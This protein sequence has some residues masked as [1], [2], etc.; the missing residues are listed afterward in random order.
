M[1]GWLTVFFAG[2][3]GYTYV[4]YP[5]LVGV[6]A[7]RRPAEGPYPDGTPATTLII[8]AFNERDVIERKLR[9]AFSLDYPDDLLQIVVVT[10]G[11][12]DGTDSVAR[13]VTGRH[14]EVL[15][16]PTRAG[17]A[18][19][20]ARGVAAATGE[21]VVFSD[22]NN[23]YPPDAIREVVRPF[24][25]PL[26]GAVTG[27]KG[28]EG[29]AADLETE[30]AYW[31]Y[32]SFIKAKES[33]LGCCTG[34]IG[35]L[36]AVRRELVPEFPPGLVND[37]FF[38]AMQVARS[39]HKVAYAP[40][41]LSLEPTATSLRSDAVR[42][43]RMTAGRWQSV[44]WW[45]QVLPLRR[46]LVVWQVASHKYLRLLLPLTMGGALLANILDV[47]T[48]RKRRSWPVVALVAQSVFYGLA[49]T[50]DRLRRPAVVRRATTV[51]RYLVR[52]NLAS[53]EG[54][55]SYVRGRG[56][57]HLWQRVARLE[58]EQPVMTAERANIVE[59]NG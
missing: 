43:R 4:G 56:G 3:T 51:S 39:G 28:V 2:L 18:A 7:N 54:F 27:A 24:A 59:A 25:D 34:V 42:R 44:M 29:G 23:L 26:V 48:D 17:K 36:L 49:G 38:I 9:N 46:P 52:S 11:S 40:S 15:H 37:D 12:D 50:P 45:R 21:I 31:K 47:A 6:L 55:V 41:A 5:V 58:A 1:F 35:E 10:D 57:L 13:S 53:A 16:D 19:A 22:A 20:M 32:E 14:V 8:S 30:G 33:R